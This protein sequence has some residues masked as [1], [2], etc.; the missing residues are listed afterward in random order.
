MQDLDTLVSIKQSLD[1]IEGLV[2]DLTKMSLHRELEQRWIT[3]AADYVNVNLVDAIE[4]LNKPYMYSEALK[5][6][7]IKDGIIAEFGVFQGWSINLLARLAPH[8][9]I[10]GFDSFEGL[11][12]DW[13]GQTAVKGS[14][15]LQGNQPSVESNVRLIKGWFHETIPRFLDLV[16][17]KPFS[18]IHVDCDTYEATK[19]VLEYAELRIVKGTI[20]I[21]DE[22]FGYRGWKNG[23]F[24]AWQ[25]FVKKNKLAYV[26]RGF[27]T[28]Q[29]VIEVL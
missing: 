23:E 22:Y 11:M 27:H 8:C 21:F 15:S 26:Y 20:I 10:F 18:F 17:N 19:T 7:S 12:E 2:S 4:F 24:K 16:P 9:L 13:K 29:V 28:E 25:E 1:R 5:R 6:I 3:E 14:F